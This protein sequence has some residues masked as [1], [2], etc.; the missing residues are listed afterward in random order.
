MAKKTVYRVRG[1]IKTTDCIKVMEELSEFPGVIRKI[2]SPLRDKKALKRHKK[3]SRFPKK[4]GAFFIILC[5]G[6]NLEEMQNLH[7]I[8]KPYLV[9]DSSNLMP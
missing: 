5:T 1:E 3:H 7:E 2:E 9:K 4:Y 8:V 6:N